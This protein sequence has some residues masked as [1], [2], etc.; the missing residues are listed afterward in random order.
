[1]RRIALCLLV[2]FA[3]CASQ[4][5]VAT[6]EDVFPASYVDSSV[7]ASDAETLAS[8]MAAIASRRLN[9][10]AQLIPAPDADPVAPALTAAIRANGGSIVSPGIVPAHRVSYQVAPMEG[11]LLARMQIDRD[12]VAQPFGRVRG[13]ALRPLGPVAVV[14][15]ARD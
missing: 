2:G 10:P 14:E 7:T 6:T 8:A 9:G 4:P 11:G 12:L 15:A 1:M 3:G 5:P 13:S